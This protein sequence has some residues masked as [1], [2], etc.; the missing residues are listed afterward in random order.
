MG[1]KLAGM[2]HKLAGMG[3][4][5]S[6]LLENS[7][8][9][10]IWSQQLA[11]AHFV[12]MLLHLLYLH[13][14]LRHV[15]PITP[16]KEASQYWSLPKLIQPTHKFKVHLAFLLWLSLLQMFLLLLKQSICLTEQSNSGWFPDLSRKDLLL[17]LYLLQVDPRTSFWLLIMTLYL[18]I[19]DYSPFF[20]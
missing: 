11:A 13:F 10:T 2:G 19:K 5:I 12:N 17:F 9:N 15:L 16:L 4:F 8:L 3:H 20:S 6:E 1:H 7:Q 18:A 14:K